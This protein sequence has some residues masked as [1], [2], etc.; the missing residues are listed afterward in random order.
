[1]EATE[2]NQFVESGR[3]QGSTSGGYLGHLSSVTDRTAKTST[4]RTV[5]LSQGR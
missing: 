2:G 5:G 3:E 1:M 4:A